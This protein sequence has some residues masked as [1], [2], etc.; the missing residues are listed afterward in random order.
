MAQTDELELLKQLLF[1]EERESLKTLQTH[2]LDP[3]QRIADTAKILAESITSATL[4]KQ[5]LVLALNGPVD[6]CIRN[7][8]AKDPQQFANTLF[9]V[10]GPAIRKAISEA[11][12][13]FVEST[14]DMIEQSMSPKSLRWR[15]EAKRS[16]VP[17]SEI[18]LKH[19]LLYRVEEVFLIQ[20]GSGLLIEHVSHPNVVANDSDAISAM[21]TVIRDFTH[22]SFSTEAGDHLETVEFGERTLWIVDGPKALLACVNR[23]QVPKA[24][25][26]L[27]LSVLEQFHSKYGTEIE[28]FSGDRGANP[29]FQDLLAT[30]LTQ[31]SKLPETDLEKKHWLRNPSLWI[32]VAIVSLLGYWGWNHYDKQRRTEALLAELTAIDG[33]VVL[34]TEDK[35]N[36]L[37]VQGLRDPLAASLDGI[38]LKHGFSADELQLQMRLYQSLEPTLAMQRA[39]QLLAAPKTVTLSAQ[40]QQLVVSGT[41]SQEWLDFAVN[42]GDRIPGFSSANFEQLKV[43]DAER[44]AKIRQHLQA[45]ETVTLRLD[46]DTLIASGTAPAAWIQNLKQQ[47]ALLQPPLGLAM[48]DQGKRLEA[49]EWLQAVSLQQELDGMSFYFSEETSFNKEEQSRIQVKLEKVAQ[50]LELLAIA[51]AKASFTVT[52]YTDGTGTT[53]INQALKRKRAETIKQLL[54]N[55]GIS[56]SAIS[57]VSGQIAD[58]VDQT[59]I[60]LRRVDLGVKLIRTD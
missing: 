48:V 30:C 19:S 16:G 56:P 60:L 47:S 55:V 21:L 14:N 59:S 36:S 11:L 24:N 45:P 29:A 42:L 31:E 3:K 5:D 4:E 17:L 13:A 34:D 33:V 2:V 20:Q 40:G 57:T 50:L 12:K 39:A 26:T 32:L 35:G 10:I 54:I 52:G 27:L 46:K 49:N 25:R 41:A 58:N 44:L 38:G 37:L 51:N 28:Q 18:I 1:N 7:L 6:E 15:W 53:D 22:D 23:G 8:V 9:P 43:D